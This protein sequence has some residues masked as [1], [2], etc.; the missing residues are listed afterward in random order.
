MIPWLSPVPVGKSQSW[1]KKTEMFIFS[2]RNPGL[3]I[4]KMAPWLYLATFI[5]YPTHSEEKNVCMY[6]I[7]LYMLNK[8]SH[9]SNISFGN[10][11]Q[12][13]ASEKK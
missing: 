5:A 10:I 6:F 1:I 9:L 13:F 7:I 8:F 3:Y 12:S 11:K 2:N 4:H